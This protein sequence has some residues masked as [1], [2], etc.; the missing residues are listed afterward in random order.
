MT[1][2]YMALK[3]Q[4]ME[5]SFAPGDR[6][7]PT[8]I[9]H[10][11]SS[12]M[13][14]VR[15]ALHRLTG[16]RIVESWQ[17][18]GFRVPLVSEA[19]LRDLYPWSLDLMKIAIRGAG[20]SRSSVR[21]PTMVSGD[22]PAFGALLLAIAERSPNYEHRAAIANL[23]DRSEPLRAVEFAVIGDGE[24][25]GL[26]AQAIGSGAMETAQALLTRFYRARL[27]AVV[28]VAA[29]VRERQG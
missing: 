17:Q 19:M 1:R 4:I 8:R 29:A 27:R 16:E 28:D 6:L 25:V 14:P 7:D 21:P 23:N 10:D 5:G 15:E 22:V 18:E 13:T 11:L 24:I 12:S 3:A 9:A 2:I 26:L 20:R